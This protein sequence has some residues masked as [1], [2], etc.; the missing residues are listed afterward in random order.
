MKVYNY[1]FEKELNNFKMYCKLT[2]N[3]LENLK[4]ELKKNNVREENFLNWLL[5]NNKYSD[6][7]PQI[8]RN[9]L[10]VSLYAFFENQLALICDYY[11]QQKN[12]VISVADLKGAGIER[13]KNY[14]K[15]V[16]QSNFPET[17][18]EWKTI[19]N[20][21][22]VRNCIVHCGGDVELFSRTID[23]RKSINRLGKSIFETER[24]KIYICKEFISEI[25][26]AMEKI[27]T[28]LHIDLKKFKEA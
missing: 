27:L 9:S 19:K 1:S 14:M 26:I 21:A 18:D 17:T 23:L 10:L 2:E 7:F 6:E 8:L 20:C 25:I 16:I 28:D 5:L 3:Q 11:K 12:I 13:A 22:L 15:K 24:N 4:H